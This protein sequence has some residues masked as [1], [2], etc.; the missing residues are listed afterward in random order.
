MARMLERLPD[1][2]LLEVFGRLLPLRKEYH[3]NG[4]FFNQG[5]VGAYQTLTSLCLTSKRLSIIATPLLYSDIIVSQRRNQHQISLLLRTILHNPVRGQQIKHIEHK[6]MSIHGWPCRDECRY[7]QH[8][9]SLVWAEHR[10]NLQSMAL[11]L[12]SN[13]KHKVWESLLDVFPDLAQLILLLCHSPN[14]TRIST[15]MLADMFPWCLDFP[16]RKLVVRI[17]HWANTDSSTWREF[18]S[19]L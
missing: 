3:G 8:Y 12:W 2:L 15:D 10:K 18:A 7:M 6:L 1:E 19:T 13:E 16:A 11:K 5:S 4:D 14:I 9:K 17:H